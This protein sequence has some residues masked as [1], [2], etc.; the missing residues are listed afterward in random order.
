MKGGREML[1]CCHLLQTEQP[2]MSLVG[3]YLV[4]DPR[5]RL[6]GLKRSKTYRN[7][8]GEVRPW[9]DKTYQVVIPAICG[10]MLGKHEKNMFIFA[11]YI[12]KYRKKEIRSL[13]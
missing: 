7:S 11:I 9:T 13:N 12:Y 3:V 1:K 10:D 6:A 4:Q 5:A 2:R 8:R